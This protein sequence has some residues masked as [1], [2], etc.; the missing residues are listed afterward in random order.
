MKLPTREQCLGYFN[1][2][3][4]PLNIKEHCLKVEEVAVFLAKKLN[5]SGKEV[6]AVLVSRIALLHD[7]FKVVVLDLENQTP[8]YNYQ[9]SEEE[10]AMWRQ[11]R[12]K[13]QGYY[14]GDVACLI[15]NKEFPELAYSLRRV[16]MPKDPDKNDEEMLVHYADWRTSQ[17]KIVSLQERLAYLRKRYQKEADDWPTDEKI[18]VKYEHKIMKLLNMLPE[19]LKERLQNG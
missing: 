4:V 12:E 17:D 5:E 16:G 11:L 9:Y 3:K 15:F 2:Y 7:I 10:L 1:E 6:D 8:P 18:I 13:Y 19:Q 14:E